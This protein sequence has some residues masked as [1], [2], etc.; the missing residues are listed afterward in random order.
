MLS[1]FRRQGYRGAVNADAKLSFWS[2][3][4]RISGRRAFEALALVA[5]ASLSAAQRSQVPLPPAPSIELRSALDGLR[6]NTILGEE[7]ESALGMLPAMIASETQFFVEGGAYLAGKHRRTE[8]VPYL[9]ASLERENRRTVD[10]SSEPTRCLLD[11]LIRL[12]A[13][14]SADVLL[15]RPQTEFASQ[16]YLLL[17]KADRPDLQGLLRFYDLGW[18]SLAGHWA[19][20]CTLVA[21]GGTGVVQRLLVAQPWPLEFVV[22]DHGAGMESSLRRG[23][24][25]RCSSHPLWPPRTRYSL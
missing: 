3:R 16:T 21:A 10:S 4:R 8:C 20:A 1:A 14:V 22:R 12:D 17:A 6:K 2:L 5:L 11:A 25:V 15:T 23:S 7:R 18:D 9:I 13:R 19:S 24:G